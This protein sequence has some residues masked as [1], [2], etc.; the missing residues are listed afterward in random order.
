MMEDAERLATREQI[1]EAMAKDI[2]QREPNV[3]AVI[4]QMQQ[5]SCNQ[6]QALN[7]IELVGALEDLVAAKYPDTNSQNYKGLAKKVI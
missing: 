4:Q 2:V 6:T 7:A 3:V 1:L 5:S